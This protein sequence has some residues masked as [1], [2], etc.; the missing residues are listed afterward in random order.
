MDPADYLAT[1]D[2]REALNRVGE[3]ADV[4]VIDA[5]PV[6]AAAD[7]T[8]LGQY[9]DGAVLIASLDHS[10][11]QVLAEAAERLRINNVPLSGVA[12]AGVRGARKMTYASTYGGRAGQSGRLGEHRIWLSRV[13]GRD[14]DLSSKRA[15]RSG[16]FSG[17]PVTE[18]VQPETKVGDPAADEGSISAQSVLERHSIQHTNGGPSGRR[19]TRAE[20]GPQDVGAGTDTEKPLNG[21]GEADDLAV[22]APEGEQPEIPPCSAPVRGSTTAQA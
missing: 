13:V 20:G 14:K 10:D 12:I 8:I 15:G 4:V 22:S 18:L 7:A 11:R 3:E 9:A 1:A 19:R 16:P 21:G 2:F 6:L 17:E 5:P